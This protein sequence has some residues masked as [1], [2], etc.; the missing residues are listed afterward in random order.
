MIIVIGGTGFIG[1]HLS[2]GLHTGK[3]KSLSVSRSPDAAFLIK[4][5]PSSVPVEISELSSESNL[6]AIKSATA[7][8]YLASNSVPS[9]P[10]NCIISE[11]RSNVRPA[12]ENIT[13]IQAINPRIRVI[14]LSSGG[15]VYGPNHST[16][17]S[18]NS[19][20]LPVTPY[21]YGKIAIEN[22]LKFLSQTSE[23]SYTILRVAN[24]VG[25]WHKN[26]SQGFVN[27]AIANIK[28]G[29]PITIFG[30]G[31][32][33]RDYV[34]VD[35]VCEAIIMISENL[36]E[37]K[38]KTWNVGSGSGSSL[39]QIIDELKTL[40]NSAITINKLPKREGDLEYNVLDCRKIHSELGWQAQLNLTKIIEKSWKKNHHST[41]N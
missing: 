15:T 22:Y 37:S 18:E 4:N 31:E 9:S 26:L 23:S 28:A 1:K 30:N 7:L 12:I 29:V 3:I 39:N 34:D 35:E 14:Y 24:P 20:L 41:P 13:K 17:I 6:A 27:A 25:H 11:W 5:A 33:I 21:A 8:V 40:S 36:E 2:V 10:K 38:N 19:Q 32:N 16:P